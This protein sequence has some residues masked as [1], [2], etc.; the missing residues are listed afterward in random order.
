MISD[1]KIIL[2]LPQRKKLGTVGLSY[3]TSYFEPEKTGK[4][5]V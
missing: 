1:H 5:G 2:E 3:F 4:I